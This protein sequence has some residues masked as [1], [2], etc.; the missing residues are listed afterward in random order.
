MEEDVGFWEREAVK[1]GS[2]GGGEGRGGVGIGDHEEAGTDGCG[3]HDWSFLGISREGR[4][5]IIRIIK[6]PE[7]TPIR[8]R[9]QTIPITA[10]T[11]QIQGEIV[12]SRRLKEKTEKLILEN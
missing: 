4:C 7:I 8:S 1:V 10:E 3:G 11:P 12:A 5:Q 9:V 6:Y 2:V